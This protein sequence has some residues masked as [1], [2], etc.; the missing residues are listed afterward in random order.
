VEYVFSF[1]DAGAAN[2][3]RFINNDA[4]VNAQLGRV[5]KVFFV[6]AKPLSLKPVEFKK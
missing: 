1:N 2:V 3:G 5:L 6:N 4:F